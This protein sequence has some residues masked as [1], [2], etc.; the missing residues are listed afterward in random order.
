MLSRNQISS[1]CLEFLAFLEI[2]RITIAALIIKLIWFLP[3]LLSESMRFLC[4]WLFCSFFVSLFYIL[5]AAP[6]KIL[7]LNYHNSY[8]ER[9]ASSGGSNKLLTWVSNTIAVAHYP[10]GSPPKVA[11]PWWGPFGNVGSIWGWHSDQ[12]GTIDSGRS[13]LQNYLQ[14]AGFVQPQRPIATHWEKTV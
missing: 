9:I 2:L 1:T 4:G 5:L 12:E 11:P 10:N 3:C 14:C 13:H 8:D 7:S 6:I